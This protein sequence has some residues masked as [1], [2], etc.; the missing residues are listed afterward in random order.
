MEMSKTIGSNFTHRNIDKLL[1]SEKRKADQT[2]ASPFAFP[3][4]SCLSE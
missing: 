2:D 1:L 3:S 4:L